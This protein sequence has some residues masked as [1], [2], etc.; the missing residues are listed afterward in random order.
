MLSKIE[1]SQVRLLGFWA[2]NDFPALTLA[3]QG[4]GFLSRPSHATRPRV[5]II[6]DSLSSLVLR[7]GFLLYEAAR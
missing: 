2:G 3:S 7:M 1:Y 4:Q 6:F 5:C